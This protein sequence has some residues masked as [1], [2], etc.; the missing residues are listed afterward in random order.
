M[1]SDGIALELSREE[2]LVLFEWL[3]RFDHTGDAAFVDR[4]EE[5]VLWDL[6]ARLEAVLVEPL[7]SR[8]EELLALAR[9]KM[10]DTSM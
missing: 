5:R 10:R 4:A 1:T 2:A 9:A 7:D 8:Y 6:H 3:T